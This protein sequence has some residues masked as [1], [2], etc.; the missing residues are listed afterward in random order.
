MS[1]LCNGK[2]SPW[3]S[4]LNR[5]AHTSQ[6]L[7]NMTNCDDFLCVYVCVSLISEASK[8]MTIYKSYTKYTITGTSWSCGRSIALNVTI[9]G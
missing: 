2:F 4:L 7:R 8:G 3:E 1:A 5:E 9:K 6:F